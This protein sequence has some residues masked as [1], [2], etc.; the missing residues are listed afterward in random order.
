MIGSYRKQRAVEAQYPA[1]HQSGVGVWP[2]LFA[3]VVLTALL[4]T[5]PPGVETI[6]SPSVTATFSPTC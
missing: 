2:L 1:C 3:L 5:P 6:V 4:V